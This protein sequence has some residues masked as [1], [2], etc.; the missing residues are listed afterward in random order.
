MELS[1]KIIGVLVGF[2]WIFGLP[3]D[4]L[5]QT[6]P[7]DELL[8]SDG[9]LVITG[10]V[11]DADSSLNDLVN[12]EITRKLGAENQ[13]VASDCRDKESDNTKDVCD[14]YYYGEPS[15]TRTIELV[16]QEEFSD[17]F[18]SILK[19]GKLKIISSGFSGKLNLIWSHISSYTT[20]T[21]DW[22]VNNCDSNTTMCDVTLLDSSSGALISE[23][24]AV[25]IVYQLI[26]GNSESLGLYKPIFDRVA[27]YFFLGM[28]QK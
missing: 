17:T 2:I 26:G 16:Y 14:I 24:H 15:E 13:F 5:A 28:L 6:D 7:F 1:K 23:M 20:D 21:I 4:V 22:A 19:D 25:D 18:L 8:N 9:K 11:I 10:S 3:K 27:L 12:N